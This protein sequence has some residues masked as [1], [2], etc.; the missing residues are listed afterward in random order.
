M[1]S[2]ILPL[3]LKQTF[4]PIIWIFTEG[5]GD[6]IESRQSFEIFSTLYFSFDHFLEAMTEI[7]RLFL[8]ELKTPEYP[9]EI[10]WPLKIKMEKLPCTWQRQMDIRTLSQPSLWTERTSLHKIL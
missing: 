5:E 3:H 10:S 4:P 6:G 1:S 2:N 9:S 8:E 7:F